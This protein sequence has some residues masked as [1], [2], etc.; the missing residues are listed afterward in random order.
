V[1]RAALLCGIAGLAGCAN[2]F[3]RPIANEHGSPGKTGS[4]SWRGVRF[5]RPAPYLLLTRE[6]L[7]VGGA[8]S[9]PV[10]KATI[11]YLPD[12]SKEFVIQWWP[13]FG[14]VAPKFTLQDG[15]NLTSFDSRVESEGAAALSSLADLLSAQPFA[16]PATRPARD[17]A[18]PGLYP[19][20]FE[21]GRWRVDW[22]HPV[23][24]FEG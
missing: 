24:R 11:V 1:K 9:V 7:R 21:E 5:Y 23:F 17:A 6:A 22:E 10:D 20:V 16:G 13:G 14:N 2:V 19:M 12:Y 3:V 15:W 4:E 8:E 18:A